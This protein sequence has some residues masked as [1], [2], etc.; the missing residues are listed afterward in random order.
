MNKL[1]L[2]VVL[3]G[4]VVSLGLMVG[5]CASGGGDATQTKGGNKSDDS[6]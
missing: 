2:W 6:N 5:A 4:L 3:V 1:K